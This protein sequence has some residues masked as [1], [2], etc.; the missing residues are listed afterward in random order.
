MSLLAPTLEAFFTERLVGQR[1]ASANTI[2]SYRDSLCLLLAFVERC[3]GT[4]PSRLDLGDLD[5]PLIGAFLDHLERERGSSVSTRNLR[6][7][8]VRSL[9]R[10]A[11]LR[12]PEH[13]AVIQRVLAIPQKSCERNE[14]SF[15]DPDEVAA[16]LAAPDRTTRI[17]RR[18]HALLV[19]AV[20]TGL[21][22]SELLALRRQDI[23]IGSGGHVTCW[24]KGRKQRSTPLTRDTAKV[25]KAWLRE[26]PASPE[27]PVFAGPRGEPLGRDAIRR[28]V[29][30]H[31]RVAQ[32]QCPS[33]AAKHVTPHTLRH[34]CAMSLLQAGVDL[35]T[36]ALWLG[37]A[38]IETTQ[39]YL[40]ADLALKERA[41]ART[42][43]TT[44]T[45]RLQRYRASDSLLA[46]LEAL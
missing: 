31:R 15:L 39:V 41:L 29:T 26:V 24:G 23:D 9:F 37:H 32:D 2:A 33:L 20:Q 34:T 3:S 10:F 46:F 22:V 11:A 17:G 1:H 43:T 36:I 44:T 4:P 14:V 13:A 7:A 40:H 25:M 42:N 35:S 19:L 6:L 12:H 27:A 38:G 45:G 18:D 28:L 16:L 21:R 30:R 5:A 8:A